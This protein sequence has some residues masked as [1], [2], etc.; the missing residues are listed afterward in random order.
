MAKSV[1][2][3]NMSLLQLIGKSPSMTIVCG[4]CY[5]EFS[6]RFNTAECR[7][8]GPITICPGCGTRNRVPVSTY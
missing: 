2:G 3:W 5:Y 6:R 8:R 4:K 7:G 1:E